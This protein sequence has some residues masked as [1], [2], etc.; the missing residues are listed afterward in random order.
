MSDRLGH[1]RKLRD[2]HE[3][4]TKGK[5]DFVNWL[6]E[7]D[8]IDVIG[9]AIGM[10]LQ[11]QSRADDTNTQDQFIDL[12]CR[13][14]DGDVT[15]DKAVLIAVTLDLSLDAHVGKVLD[16]VHDIE[17]GVAVWL[18][19]PFT[20]S[21]RH[22]LRQLNRITK[23]GLSFFGVE[24]TLWC[25]NDSEP[26]LWMDVVAKPDEWHVPVTP[27]H[28]DK[29]EKKVE[30]KNKTK[31]KGREEKTIQKEHEES[32]QMVYW[33]VLRS[34]AHQQN[35][36]LLTPMDD[37]NPS[38]V[39]F[40]IGSHHFVFVVTMNE[41]QSLLIVSLV[42]HGARSHEL[43]K[44]LRQSRQKIEW[45]LGMSL[46][47]GT[48]DA[49]RNEGCVSLHKEGVNVT[50]RDGWQEQ[51]R[52]LMASLAS[53]ERVFRPYIRLLESKNNSRRLSG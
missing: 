53:L 5:P 49:E 51:Y 41:R 26:A 46:H 20:M 30:A 27:R 9:H 31:E 18:A 3:V 25:I 37:N 36:F 7:A 12:I 47:W 16:A 29:K 39:L 50:N 38:Q 33:R 42:C 48:H 40:D 1:F 15:R 23:D 28:D 22:A 19:A 10:N 34:Y 6:C 17:E 8:H 13:G 35:D 4:W 32:S 21:H 52:W 24:V 44:G 2:L 14:N 45:E 11:L 43:F